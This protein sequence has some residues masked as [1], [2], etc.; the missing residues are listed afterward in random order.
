[1]RVKALAELRLKAFFRDFQV[2]RLAASHW[3]V[4]GELKNASVP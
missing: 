2:R 3:F 4:M 1:M